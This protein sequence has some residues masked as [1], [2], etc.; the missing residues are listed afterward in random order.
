M[1]ELPEMEH[2]KNMLIDRIKGAV[3]TD[4]QINR[5]KSVNKPPEEFIHYVKQQQIIRIDRRAKYLLFYL[6][7]GF[8]LLLHLMLGGW[9]Y[10]GTNDDK[11]KRTIQVQLNFRD[12]HLYFIG[13]RLGYLHLLTIE[14]ANQV[15]SNLGPEPLSSNFTLNDFLEALA[16]KG[17]KL[18]SALI[19]QNFISGIGNRYS[20]EICYQAKLLP[21]RSIKA[22]NNK[23]AEM[24]YKAIQT[25]LK[26]AIESGGYLKHPFYKQDVAT[27]S[28]E[29]EFRVHDRE[30]ATCERCGAKIVLERIASRNTFYCPGCQT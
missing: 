13:L 5:P 29:K 19:D 4:V 20:D 11:P 30:G 25:Q 15:L 12:N 28:Y 6:D 22:I 2:Y 17:G 23:E 9:M 24:L 14:E 1:P 18:K 26:T 3:I 27:G 8:I 21:M 16:N 10:W 7:N